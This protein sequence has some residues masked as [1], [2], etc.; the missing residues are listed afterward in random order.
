MMRPKRRSRIPGRQAWMTRKDP[1]R[2]TS[3]SRDHF[4]ARHRMRRG[5]GADDARCGNTYVD[6]PHRLCRNRAG[7]Q[8]H[9]HVGRTRHV[10]RANRHTGGTQ[11]ITDCRP[12]TSIGARHQRRALRRHFISLHQYVCAFHYFALNPASTGSATAAVIQGPSG[13]VDDAAE[14][15]PQPKPQSAN[16]G[17]RVVLLRVTIDGFFP[18]R[19]DDTCHT[20]PKN[21]PSKRIEEDFRR[22]HFALIPLRSCVLQLLRVVAFASMRR[23]SA[24]RQC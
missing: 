22:C 7:G 5:E 10:H 9:D 20:V 18:H 4:S 16:Q 15:Q 8:V 17:N 13:Y 3:I 2:L 12:D 19:S 6:V 11:P 24:G 23:F 14:E 21:V 1:V